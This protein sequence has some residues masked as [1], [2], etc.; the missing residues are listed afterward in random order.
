VD[1]GLSRDSID[2]RGPP[3]C[4]TRQERCRAGWWRFRKL[5]AA[6]RDGVGF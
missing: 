4:G 3:C 6:R 2:T 5:P 1:S